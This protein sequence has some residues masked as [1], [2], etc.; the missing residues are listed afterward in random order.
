MVRIEPYI[1]TY[2]PSSEVELTR[3]I[4]NLRKSLCGRFTV[5]TV[6]I[7]IYYTVATLMYEIIAY[8]PIL[9]TSWQLMDKQRSWHAK[10]NTGYSGNRNSGCFLHVKPK[11]FP[12]KIPLYLLMADCV[13][14]A[15]PGQEQEAVM[16]Q[17][18]NP[19]GLNLIY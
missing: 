13:I 1:W 11:Q 8:R 5:E 3:Y 6:E 4:N 9:Y 10:D 15:S 17:I 14:A 12:S 16:S 7:V 19:D 18:V 2:P